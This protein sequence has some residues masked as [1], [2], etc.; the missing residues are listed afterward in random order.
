[1]LY[2]CHACL[3][4][5]NDDLVTEQARKLENAL[6]TAVAFYLGLLMGI[7]LLYISDYDSD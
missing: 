4:Q 1:M 6:K 5:K 2:N 7:T 3:S